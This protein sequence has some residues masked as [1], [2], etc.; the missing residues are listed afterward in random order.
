MLEKIIIQPGPLKIHLAAPLLKE[1]EAFLSISANQ[2]VAR[3]FL[4]NCAEYTL[5]II[6]TFHLS[7]GN[8]REVRLEEIAAAAKSMG[9][10]TQKKLQEQADPIKRG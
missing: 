10:H 7:D 3:K 8:L 6:E 9:L 5:R 2:G 1:R 4:V